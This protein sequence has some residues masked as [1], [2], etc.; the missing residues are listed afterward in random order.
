MSEYMIGDTDC[1]FDIGN[2]DGSALKYGIIV[3]YW[4]GWWLKVLSLKFDGMKGLDAEVMLPK[5]DGTKLGAL[6]FIFIAFLLWF[7][8]V[9]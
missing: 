1:L 3:W 8:G 2:F 6:R 5:E 9:W 4:L 7:L